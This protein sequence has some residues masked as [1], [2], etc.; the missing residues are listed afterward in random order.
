MSRTSR[1]TA[2][3]A[4]VLGGT[5]MAGGLLAGVALA[6]PPP[7]GGG[8]VPASVAV[9]ETLMFAFTN[10]TGAGFSVAPGATDTGAV[11][12]M[13]GTNCPTG[14][15]VSQAAPDLSN[16]AGSNLPAGSL[17]D[18][19]SYTDAVH[20]GGSSSPAAA[21]TTSPTLFVAPTGASLAAGDTYSQ[22][23][24]AAAVPQNQAPGDYSTTISYV[25]AANA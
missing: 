10:G 19:L 5:A 7:G 20:P 3:F 11:S 23:W 2:R 8:N 15:T 17:S 1:F 6:A 24:T 14:Y 9:A 13:V 16:G 4:A 21:L 22:A 18:V 25:A 12:F